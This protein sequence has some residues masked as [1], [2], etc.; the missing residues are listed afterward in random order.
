MLHTHNVTLETRDRDSK[1]VASCHLLYDSLDSRRWTPIVHE[2]GTVSLSSPIM[3]LSL[4]LTVMYQTA[5]SFVRTMPYGSPDM[6]QA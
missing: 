3:R 1:Y 2:F 6:M 5:L 4:W